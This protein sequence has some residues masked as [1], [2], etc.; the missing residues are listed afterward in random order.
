VLVAQ[1]GRDVIQQSA[2]RHLVPVLRHPPMIEVRR[3]G[4]H[5]SC[6]SFTPRHVR[7]S[8]F[9]WQGSRRS[10][11]A[12]ENGLPGGV[13]ISHLSVYD[14]PAEDGRCGGTPHMHLA[15]SEGYVVTGGHGV[16]QTL[17]ASGFEAT[18][19]QAGTVDWFTPGTIHR[20]VNEGDLRITVLMQNSGLPEAG[21]GAQ[22]VDG[23]AEGQ[24][25][26]EEVTRAPEDWGAGGFQ[27]VFGLAEQPDLPMPGS[28]STRITAGLSRQASTREA[29]SS[30]RPTNGK[31]VRRS[32]PGWPARVPDI[33]C[34]RQAITQSWN[35]LS[36][37]T[38]D[39]HG[40]GRVAGDAAPWARS[41][42]DPAHRAP[43]S[44]RGSRQPSR[45]GRRTC[46]PLRLLPPAG[47]SRHPI[48]RR[49][50]AGRA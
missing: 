1:S 8:A 27:C 4:S 3:A 33:G 44:R 9:F 7:W 50:A 31:P 35:V 18:R 14:W 37:S 22:R 29:S 6:Q 19:L 20:L 21:D 25:L 41:R 17:T 28:P 39:A 12:Y 15:C 24:W 11:T 16:V 10:M 49:T 43:L 5:W 45:R 13:A 40:P 48:P 36:H 47:G 26:A 30:S 34:S 46:R 2:K 42:T 32:N 23:R 38:Y